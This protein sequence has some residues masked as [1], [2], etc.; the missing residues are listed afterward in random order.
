MLDG[1]WQQRQMLENNRLL[2]LAKIVV[3]YANIVE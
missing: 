3:H 2:K 1:K